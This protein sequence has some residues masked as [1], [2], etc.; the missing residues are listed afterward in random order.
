MRDAT[1]LT[2]PLK[3]PILLSLAFGLFVLISAFF[4]IAAADTGFHIR[5]GA[6]VWETRTIPAT[7]TFAHSTP[8]HHWYLQQ[9][10]P[11]TLFYLVY[12]HFGTSGLIC[13]KALLCAAIYLLLLNLCQRWQ[14]ETIHR[15]SIIPYLVVTIIVVMSRDRFLVRPFL[16]SALLFTLLLQQ[17]QKNDNNPKWH[18]LGM[19]LLMTLWANIHAGV[20][21]GFVLLCTLAAGEWFEHALRLGKNKQ[22]PTGP[23]KP[24]Y[25]V[26]QHLLMKPLG[27]L[28][29]GLTCAL[30]LELINPNGIKVAMVPLDMFLTPFW[31]ENTIEFFPPTLGKHP[32][33]FASIFSLLCLGWYQRQSIT[34]DR[35]LIT[36]L[37]FVF[38]A[39]RSMRSILFYGLVAA[40]LATLLLGRIKLLTEETQTQFLTPFNKTLSLLGLWGFLIV[41]I[42]PKDPVYRP[43]VGYEP[44]FYPAEIYHLIETEL[45]PQNFFHDMRYGGS[46]LWFLYPNHRPFIDGRGTCYA[47]DFWKQDYIPTLRGDGRWEKVFERYD[48]T[49]ALLPM[50]S[51]G[52]P[53]KLARILWNRPDWALLAFDNHGLLFAKHTEENQSIVKRHAYQTIWPGDTKFQFQEKADPR[54]LA[55]AARAYHFHPNGRFAQTAY[56]RAALVSKDYDEAIPLY[57]KLIT[58]PGASSAYWKDLGFA[59]FD[60]DQ[61]GEAKAHFQ[62]MV[63]ASIEPGYAH[64]MLHYLALLV[65]QNQTTALA[66]LRSALAHE[67]AN[68][69]YKT[70][71]AELEHA[72]KTKESTALK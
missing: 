2:V 22:S 46:M 3:L 5:T 47:I 44:T 62:K 25:L 29:A 23:L 27:I 68:G 41:F 35:W 64:H 32:L 17:C 69:A 10:A 53:P 24:T 11:A 67:P 6:H 9:W 18:Y 58:M 15:Q 26:S 66:H 72:V 71:L 1:R 39:W 8:D 61:Y 54:A 43:G 4:E 14:P 19:P 65:D 50:N 30:S 37:V 28:I 40:P 45:P 31:Q 60:A 34:L 55:E 16:F 21:Y 38:L 20:A 13:L 56:A 36:L 70:S 52:S 42:Y 12:T 48:I 7:N 63:F 59:L 51:E 33:F 57:R 49:A